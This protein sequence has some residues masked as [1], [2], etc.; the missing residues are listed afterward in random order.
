M[1]TRAQV[2]F[3]GMPASDSVRGSIAT[4]IAQ[5][6]KRFGRI[7]ACRVNVKAPSEH[8][9]NGGLY[10]VHIRLALPNK[11]E[12][13]IERTPSPDERLANLRFA[14]ND[15]FHHARRQLQDQVREMQGETK[16][17]AAAKRVKP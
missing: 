9:R 10:E 17:R 2:S 7:T 3:E 12:V 5:L 16:T 4:H 1:Q 13:N 14:I 8:H 15:A 6:E 11:R